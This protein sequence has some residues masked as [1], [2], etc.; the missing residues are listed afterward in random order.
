MDMNRKMIGALVLALA[1]AGAAFYPTLKSD[2]YT[3]PSFH[4]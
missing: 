4:V 1:I 3:P 2:S